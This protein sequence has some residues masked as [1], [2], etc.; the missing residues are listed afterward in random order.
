[1]GKIIACPTCRKKGDWLE[2]RFGPFCSHRCKM[3]DL[4]KWLD[5]EHRISEHL[6]STEIEGQEPDAR[7]GGQDRTSPPE[8]S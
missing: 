8:L 3:I 4:G 1:M 6:D 2:G 7:E 5:G